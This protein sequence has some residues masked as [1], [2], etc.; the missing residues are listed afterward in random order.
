MISV[1]IDY[2]ALADELA[3]RLEPHGTP[4]MTVEEAA[5]YLRASKSW[6]RARLY[7]IPHRKVDGKILIHRRELDDWVNTNHRREI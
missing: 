3:K 2:E 6:V 4:W 7:E 5:E 1:D